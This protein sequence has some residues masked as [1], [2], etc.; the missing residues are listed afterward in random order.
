MGSD[1]VVFAKKP[2][3]RQ[4]TMEHLLV[5]L[6][7]FEDMLNSDVF[8][9]QEQ[10]LG[11]EQELCF[12]NET[13][14]PAPVVLEVLPL[15]NDPHFVTELA[16]FNME[17]NLDPMRFTG[18]CFSDLEKQ[19]VNYLQRAEDA[20]Q[21]LDAHVF[22]SGILPTIRRSDVALHNLT[23]LKRYEYL[24]DY[25][26]E[27]REGVFEFRIDGTDP[28]ITKDTNAMFEGC[29]T[30]FQIHYQVEPRD[31]RAA[32]NWA[33]AITG[34]VLS[35][36]TNSPFL[37]GRRLWRETRIALFEQAVD[38]RND[39]QLSRGKMPRVAFGDDW[40]HE[41]VLDLHKENI[42]RYRI[43]LAPT[44][45]ED[46]AAVWAAGKVPQLEAL[47]IHNGTI[48]RWNRPC[49][50]VAG[51]KP[52]LRIENR[53]IPSG[54]TIKDEVAN[55]TFWLGLMKGMPDHYG[56]IH[57][58]QD[59]DC[60]RDNFFYAAK[61]GLGAHFSWPGLS[62]RIVAE[63]LLLHELLPIAREG[64]KQAGVKTADADLYLGIIEERTRTG[65]TG[66]QWMLDAFS[67]M[68]KVSSKDEALVALTAGNL[69]RQQ[70]GQP[71]H[72]WQLPK[73]EEAGDWKNRYW[74][75][76]QIM[77]TDLF[78]ASPDDIVNFVANIMRWRNIRHVP[79]E[80]DQGE[81]LGLV[82]SRILTEYFS[83]HS[84]SDAAGKTVHDIME[85][86]LTTVS[87][88]TL[89]IDAIHLMLERG[90]SCLPVTSE[91]ELV[92]VVTERDFL[93][94]AAKFLREGHP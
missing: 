51:G 55:A 22:L 16:R 94:I 9:G 37:V 32:Y 18:A 80:N 60:A 53:V 35:C 24:L 83:H 26:A 8:E 89:T 93:K 63:E 77:V 38:M 47:N 91:G 7:V 90:I 10:H 25:L 27:M 76:E 64:L 81:L 86:E 74:T 79:I 17:I 41:S 30:S 72:T 14:R 31:F 61:Q 34:P 13:W 4:R 88:E 52:H 44:E 75:V 11:I 73:L 39:T 87:P 70:E 92:G 49:Y 78:T 33:Q 23:P 54:P 40:I 5:D 71:V 12:V 68:S 3:T 19:L 62:K 66:S 84:A 48:W 59:F 2:A 15:I 21:S 82:S 50:G 28:L 45:P 29:N 65:R 20:A 42:A 46:S 43:M 1:K 6:K 58:L 56:R 36:A 57:E 69:Q 67:R 85:T